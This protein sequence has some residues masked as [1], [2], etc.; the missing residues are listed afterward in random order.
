MINTQSSNGNLTYRFL[1]SGIYPSRRPGV[2]IQKKWPTRVRINFHFPSLRKRRV[3]RCT[4]LVHVKLISKQI[5]LVN[6]AGVFVQ[7]L[8]SC[9]NTN[10]SKREKYERKKLK[11]SS[12]ASGPF[13][14]I[15]QVALWVKRRALRLAVRP[16]TKKTFLV[17]D[18]FP[19]TRAVRYRVLGCILLGLFWNRNSW[20]KPNNCSFSCYDDSRVAVKPS[21]WHC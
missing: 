3:A 2:V 12:V 13:W 7:D 21:Q 17:L 6:T 16:R 15:D 4:A 5:T 10:E 20:N 11:K 8:P 18:E 19:V 14:V 1:S 9:F